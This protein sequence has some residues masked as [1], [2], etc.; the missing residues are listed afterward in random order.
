MA[1][2]YVSNG[3]RNLKQNI[4]YV[5][6]PL[7]LA[8]AVA[9]GK[10]EAIP[11]QYPADA[12][13]S[14]AH[15]TVTVR[16]PEPTIK[17]SLP[18]RYSRKLDGTPHFYDL[19]ACEQKPDTDTNLET[20]LQQTLRTN[21]DLV[22]EEKIFNSLDQSNLVYVSEEHNAEPHLTLEYEILEHLIRQGKPAVLAMEMFYTDHNPVINQY[23]NGEI[24]EEEFVRRTWSDKDGFLLVNRHFFGYDCYRDLI[25]LAKKNAVR[26]KGLDLNHYDLWENPKYREELTKEYPEWARKLTF[27]GDRD[28]YMGLQ[29]SKIQEENPDSVVLVI[30]HA[31]HIHGLYSQEEPSS[32]EAHKRTIPYWASR[33]G[34]NN[35][36]I[37]LT[38]I[39]EP[40]LF[41]EGAMRPT[42]ANHPWF[43]LPTAHSTRGYIQD[44]YIGKLPNL[45]QPVIPKPTPK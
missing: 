21:I 25:N 14:R 24:N 2:N 34:T 42:T 43:T 37:S 8:L 39:M 4:G 20:I 35:V 26:I 10:G 9:C 19:P 17:L 15:P 13:T 12:P 6:V 33:F 38:T 45:E 32:E 41:P 30:A 7:L 22:D 5:I 18:E 23:L 27:P 16:P 40:K 11:A 1:L 3:L 36:A 44:F 29:V 31:A 28:A